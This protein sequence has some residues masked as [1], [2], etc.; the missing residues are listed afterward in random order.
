[1]DIESKVAF[2]PNDPRMTISEKR[3]L[4][5]IAMVDIPIDTFRTLLLPDFTAYIGTGCL[6]Q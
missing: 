6:M 5:G 4:P 1:M 3:M 2:S